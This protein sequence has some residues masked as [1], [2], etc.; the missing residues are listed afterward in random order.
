MV[1]ETTTSTAPGTPAPPQGQRS[2]PFPLYAEPA[3]GDVSLGIPTTRIQGTPPE[4]TFTLEGLQ[5]GQYVLRYFGGPIKSI[6]V[7]GKDFTTKPLDATGGRDLTGVVVTI[8]A[9]FPKLSGTVKDGRGQPAKSGSVI[10]F[11]V[12]HEQWSGYGFSPARLLS[13]GIASDGT[14]RYG[15][16]R[17]GEYFVIAVDASLAT[18][19]QDP[20]FL[21]AAAALATRVS[22]DW[23]DTKSLEL[24]IKQIPGYKAP[25]GRP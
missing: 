12:D 19:W 4:A 15:T 22:L 6:T 3:Y 25:G 14:F 9:T 24:G 23:T 8:P 11:P 7:D 2:I 17:A 5:P 1:F 18:A 20:K 10:I 13:T 16:L 21:E